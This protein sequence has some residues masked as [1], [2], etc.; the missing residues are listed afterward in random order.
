MFHLSSRLTQSPPASPTPS[1]HPSSSETG[2]WPPPGSPRDSSASWGVDGHRPEPAQTV[3]VE[4]EAEAVAAIGRARPLTEAAFA[5]QG[6]NRGLPPSDTPRCYTFPGRSSADRSSR[7]RK[8]F[9]FGRLH[10]CCLD[11]FFFLSSAP[12]SPR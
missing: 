11:V 4:T 3:I 7:W 12:T 1:T 9:I 8:L 5:K 10:R 6:D 2:P